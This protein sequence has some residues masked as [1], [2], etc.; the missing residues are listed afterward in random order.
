[1][2]GEN[3]W[4]DGTAYDRYIGRWSRVV[5]RAFLRWLDVPA[6][7]R[8]MDVGCGTGAL[9]ET[10]L[11]DAEPASVLGVDRSEGFLAVAREQIT[12][13]RAEFRVA[14]AQALPDTR[15]DVV[16]SGLVLN[17]VPSPEQ[18]VAGFRRVLEPDGV[19]AAYLWDL[20]EGM[21]MIRTFWDAAAQV[22]PEVADRTEGRVYPLCRP[23][24][25]AELWSSQFA[26][27]AVMP[28]E[29]PTV[30]ADFDDYWTPFLGRQGPAP[31]YLASLTD[32]RR[33]AIRDLLRYQLP[34]GPD[35]EIVLAATAWAV[36]GRA[37]VAG[38]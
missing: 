27:V 4:A 26:D 23:E 37:T 36:R 25:L 30:F 11:A 28:I 32:E 6:G 18:A 12:D 9:T 7:L 38:G 19:A 8:W 35:G 34:T 2:A 15:A 13:P 1:M 21:E 17:F 24:P 22:D 20:A 3:L 10:V 31:T 29:V 33:N 14:D 16:V 5:A